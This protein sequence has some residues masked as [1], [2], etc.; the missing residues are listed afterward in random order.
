LEIADGAR[1]DG[2]PVCCDNDTA[3][4]KLGN[5][6]TEYTCGDCRNVLEFD[7]PA[8]SPT[9]EREPLPELPA[10]EQAPADI[11]GRGLRHV[12]IILPR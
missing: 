2:I 10:S 11:P 4:K 8:S 9:S 7:N 3:A 1:L 6:D 5:G 12:H